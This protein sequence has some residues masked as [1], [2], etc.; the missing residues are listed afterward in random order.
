MKY[1]IFLF[2]LLNAYNADELI[3]S[4]PKN[5]A[6]YNLDI[7]LYKKI[8]EIKPQNIQINQNI[9]NESTKRE[10]RISAIDTEIESWKNLKC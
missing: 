4:I 1:I 5:S 3:K 10:E 6:E 8:K 9:K 7:V 2:V